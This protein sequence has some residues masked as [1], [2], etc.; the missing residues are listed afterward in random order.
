MLFQTICHFKCFPAN[1][2]LF[3]VNNRYT[4]KRYFFSLNFVGYRLFYFLRTKS[5]S[6][7]EIQMFN[8]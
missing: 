7:V 3:K 8:G 2:F 4:R 1:I 5:T 6:Q